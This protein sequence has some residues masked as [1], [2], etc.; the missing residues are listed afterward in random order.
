MILF[1]SFTQK[2]NKIK[3]IVL[4]AQASVLNPPRL[5]GLMT[6]DVMLKRPLVLSLVI[7]AH[8]GSGGG[9]LS[10]VVLIK[11]MIELHGYRWSFCRCN[12]AYTL[13]SGGM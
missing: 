4:D 12:N 6:V 10:F 1:Y 13:I 2:Y 7:D 11:W 9:D 8:D 3:L 5:P